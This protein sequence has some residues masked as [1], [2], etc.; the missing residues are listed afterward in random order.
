[1]NTVSLIFKLHKRKKGG[2]ENENVH[3]RCLRFVGLSQVAMGVQ[4][5]S[6]VQVC[7]SETKKQIKFFLFIIVFI[8]FNFLRQA[9]RVQ[10]KAVTVFRSLV[11]SACSPLQK[12]VS[13]E[14]SRIT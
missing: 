10:S 1:M 9:D 5:S 13:L 4:D 11:S 12:T 8:L 7:H 6:Q 3:I 14:L 2:E